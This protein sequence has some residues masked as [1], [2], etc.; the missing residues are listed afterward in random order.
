VVDYRVLGPLEVVGDGGP[1]ALGSVQQRAVLALLI[2]HAPEIVS[3]DRLIDELWGER[4][5]TTAPHAVQVY[6]SA[7]RKTLRNATAGAGV[8]LTRSGSGYVLEVDP[9]RVDATRFQMLVA[10]AQRALADAPANASSLFEEALELWRG[11][12]LAELEFQFAVRERERLEELHAVAVEGQVDARLACGA[13]REVIGTITGLVASNPLREAPRRLLMLA[14]YR[15]GRHAEALAAYRDACEALDEIGLQP[16]PELRQLERAILQHD[17]ALNLASGA[18]F[19]STGRDRMLAEQSSPASCLPV[20]E[21]RDTTP[22]TE[23]RFAS[24]LCVD[25]AGFATLSEPLQADD[26]ADLLSHYFESSRT[27]VNRYG[28]TIQ[29]LAGDALM[30]VW[31]VPS[32][33]ED[34]AERAVRAA[35][36]IVDAVGALGERVGTPGLRGRAGVVTGQV[37]AQKNPDGEGLVIGGPVNTAARMPSAAAPGVVLVDDVTREVTSAAIVFE[38]AGVQSIDGRTGRLRL[39][40]AVR[41][42]AGVSRAQSEQLLEASFVGREADLRLLKELFHGALERRSAW[43]VAV[44]GEAGIGKSRL[45]WEFMKHTDGLA[46][47]FLWHSGRCPPFG[48]GVA[49]WPLAEMIRQRLGIAEDASLADASMK[50]AEGLDRWVADAAHRAFLL[51]RLG[52][53]LGLAQPGLSRAELFA[54]W[55]LFFEQLATHEP[56]LLVFEDLHWADIGV[57]DFIE[58]LLEWSAKSPIFILTLARPDLEARRGG[59]PAVHRGTTQVRLDPLVDAAIGDLLDDLVDGLPRAARERIVL[60][61]EGVPLYVTE[62]VRMLA[63]RGVLDERDGRFVPA[64]EV[65]E[66][67][68]PASLS[69]LLAA[70]LDALAPTERAFVR[71]MSVFGGSFSRSTAVALGD[72]PDGEVDNVL[73]TLVRRQVLTIRAD[74]LSPDRG[75]YTFAQGLLRQVAY[76]M[77]S[78]RERKPRHLA[79][80]EHLRHLLTND[81]EDAAEMIAAHYLEAWRAAT[82]DGDI[83][84]LRAD[85]IAALSRAAQR[86]ETVGA[87]EAAER[88]YL[89]A[90]EL[91]Q[92]EA[93]RASLTQAAG[94]MAWT[95]GRSEAAL[96]LFEEASAAHTAAGRTLDAA[97]TAIDI[98]RALTR[99]GRANDAAD[100]LADAVEVLATRPHFEEELATA[101]CWLARALLEIAEYERASAAA[102]VALAI[103]QA[104]TLPKLWSQALDAKGMIFHMTGRIDE[105]RREYAAAAEIAARYDLTELAARLLGNAANLSYLWDLPEAASQFEAAIEA[106]R[107]RGDRYLEGVSVS[108]LMAIHLLAG[109]WR[110][111]ERIAVEFLDDDD[112]RAG[113]EFIHYPLAILHALRGDRDAAQARLDRITAWQRSQAA[114]LRATHTAAAICLSL[115]DGRAHEALEQGWSML[116][117]TI[118]A[119]GVAHDAVRQAWPD[120]LQA[121]IQSRHLK[122]AHAV[123]SLLATRPKNDIP[124]YLRAHL[125]RGQALTAA[126]EDRHDSVESDLHASIDGFGELGYRYWLAVAQTDLGAWLQSRGRRGEA[127]TPLEE[128]IEALQVIGAGQALARARTELRAASAPLVS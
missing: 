44:S 75:Q 13:H 34:D 68:V 110:E 62:T 15:A 33:H 41:V 118:N 67:D 82:G 61:A 19:T 109:R 87:P 125:L 47:R 105:A 103:A 88:A 101:N 31:G 6:V 52:A 100:R 48:D 115:A 72:L 89:T 27:I 99:L 127:A 46:Q 124:P 38:D 92:D 17:E 58:H 8:G 71:A 95:S 35:F 86:A 1:V 70:R 11:P 80:A 20:P 123:L 30:A 98:G 59:W 76:E 12:P 2:V 79:A 23:L 4:P 22:L 21:S 45:R 3:I 40:R 64:G 65:R 51:P 74:P 104:H 16:G 84:R 85:T 63:S 116:P 91:E 56:V 50:L 69:S 97:R 121:A 77:L 78:R 39:W 49:Y 122:L 102:D 128:A 94:R 96:E 43:L 108:N 112:Q 5:P 37:A 29:T 106:D 18:E 32:A 114:E 28:G 60:R 7:I 93:E 83:E 66:L 26:E 81:G 117:A 57:L 55:R 14:L 25:L 73:A 54:G 90:R 126:A 36:D 107:R 42:V 119:L 113:A 111:A 10:T 9:Q 24:I 120:T 53:L